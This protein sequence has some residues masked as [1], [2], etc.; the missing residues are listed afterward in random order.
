MAMPPEHM[1][2][3]HGG[4]ENREETPCHFLVVDKILHLF[5]P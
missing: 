2:K 4:R 5:Y 3:R 1:E